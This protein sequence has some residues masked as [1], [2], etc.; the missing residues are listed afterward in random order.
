MPV[1]LFRKYVATLLAT[2][3]FWVGYISIFHSATATY[4]NIKPLCAYDTLRNSDVSDDFWSC[5]LARFSKL[6]GVEVDHESPTT[7]DWAASCK[8]LDVLADQSSTKE[9]LDLFGDAADLSTECK[10]DRSPLTPRQVAMS[11]ELLHMLGSWA[12]ER[13]LDKGIAPVHGMAYAHNQSFPLGAIH[14][15]GGGVH[16]MV[17]QLMFRANPSFLDVWTLMLTLCN[18]STL[19]SGYHFTNC[20]HGA[21]HGLIMQVAIPEKPSAACAPFLPQGALIDLSGL[22]RA[23]DICTNFPEISNAC[24]KCCFD[25][26]YH[27]FFTLNVS[28]IEDTPHW[29]HPCDLVSK[30]ANCFQRLSYSGLL[31]RRWTLFTSKKSSPGFSLADSSVSNSVLS[32]SGLDCQLANWSLSVRSGCVFAMSYYL[33]VRYDFARVAF[34]RL[35][36]SLWCPERDYFLPNSHSIILRS[37]ELTIPAREAHSLFEFCSSFGS[38]AANCEL[39]QSCIIGSAKGVDLNAEKFNG[40]SVDLRNAWSSS[41]QQLPTQFAKFC[42]AVMSIYIKHNVISAG[43]DIVTILAHGV[44]RAMESTECGL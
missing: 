7:F 11:T 18:T 44:A 32:F 6:F 37:H 1:L 43:D 28:R 3:S 22:L 30:P 21:A 14:Q 40:N 8:A 27:A 42:E 13:I 12:A 19:P 29:A 17:W 36:Q 4:S 15:Q 5:R 41:C 34:S 33:F 38:P 2:T 31:L 9:V 26:I 16:G 20:M 35:S 24:V 25:G 23:D 10:I 39:W